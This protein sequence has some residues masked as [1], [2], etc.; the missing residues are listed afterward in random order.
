MA[1]FAEARVYL[2]A[3]I[4]RKPSGDHEI[5]YNLGA[6]AYALGDLPAAEQ[7]FAEA[8]ADAPTEEARSKALVQMAYP[9]LAGG[10]YQRGLALYEHRFAEIARTQVW[11][12]GIPEWRGEDLGAKHILV[13]GDQGSGDDIQ[14]GRFLGALAKRAQ[15]V[16]LAVPRDLMPLFTGPS[17]R[18]RDLAVIDIGGD[19]PV[20]DYHSGTCSYPRYLDLELPPKK[21]RPYIAAERAPLP[22]PPGTELTI[23]LVWAPRPLG[24]ISARRIVPL[25]GLLELAAIPGVALY[26]LQVGEAASELAGGAGLLVEDLSRRLRDWGDTAQYMAALDLIISVDSAPLHLAGAMGRPCIG[27]LPYVPCWRW[28]FGGA[29]GTDGRTPWYPTMRLLRQSAPGDWGGVIHQLRHAVQ[30]HKAWPDRDLQE[31]GGN[32]WR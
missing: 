17:F 19:L 14:F 15:R 16:T 6:V 23:G 25:D 20:A 4:A 22:K 30:N 9:V 24:E 21:F 18:C 10:D 28:G 27:L 1:R 12:L 11:E 2:E 26:S 3:A 7:W 8:A 29:N 13:H 31:K 5:P 32:I